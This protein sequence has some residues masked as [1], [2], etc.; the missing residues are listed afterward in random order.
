MNIS[1]KVTQIGN[2]LGLI[3]PKAAANALNVEKGDT[4][5]L[6]SSPGGFCITANDPAFE[7][8]MELARK[9]MKRRRSALRELAK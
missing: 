8:R 2:S 7:E 6:T 1:L 5:L 9:I 4:V 3:L